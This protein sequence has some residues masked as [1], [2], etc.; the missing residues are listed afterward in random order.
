M[1]PASSRHVPAGAVSVTKVSTCSRSRPATSSFGTASGKA[2]ST[3]SK[4][5]RA[6]APKRSRKGS[7]VNIVERLAAKSGMALSS[8]EAGDHPALTR[9]RE[10]GVDCRGRHVDAA[11]ELL[12]GSDQRVD[13]HR[14][15]A[16]EILQHRGLVRA[17]ARRPVDAPLDID[18]AAHSEALTDRLRLD[19]HRAR[20]LA[21]TGIGADDIERGTGQRADRVE[22]KIAPQLEPD[23]V[24][25]ALADRRVE[26][27]RDHDLGE[28]ADARAEGPVG[29]ADRQLVA[30]DV[31]DDA[32]CDDLGGGIDDAADG[33]VGTENPPLHA[34]GT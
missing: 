26:P 5:Q 15:A 34:A 23:L 8:V 18:A 1:P 4:P 24:A 9:Q 17:D 27:G 16:L 28:P 33:A 3:A 12:D 25:D 30:I 7:S 6:A 13:L 11:A 29:L 14:P 21:G 2:S 20:H 19:H 10:N 22:G 31:L 32:R